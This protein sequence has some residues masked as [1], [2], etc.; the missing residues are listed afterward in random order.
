MTG[1]GSA[2]HCLRRFNFRPF[3]PEQDQNRTRT[4]PEQDGRNTKKEDDSK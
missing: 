1:G 4:G 3:G 2:W